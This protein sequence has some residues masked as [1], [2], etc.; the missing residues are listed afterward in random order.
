MFYALF[1]QFLYNFYTLFIQFLY[2]VYT[3]YTICETSAMTKD[4]RESLLASEIPSFFSINES[5]VAGGVAPAPLV[6]SSLPPNIMAPS[7]PMDKKWYEKRKQIK[8]RQITKCLPY[9]II[10]P[11]SYEQKKYKIHKSKSPT[12]AKTPKLTKRM[13]I[14]EDEDDEEKKGDEHMTWVL[15][16]T[17]EVY[18][19][20]SR[21]RSW[22]FK[23]MEDHV[24]TNHLPAEY[25]RR[26][27]EILQEWDEP[28]KRNKK[29]YV[30]GIRVCL[31][32][33][34]IIFIFSLYNFY[35]FFI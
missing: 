18:T 30:D 16:T 14:D 22:A 7:T 29:S 21:A 4:G 32:F 9:I 1:I 28:E 3:G 33:L 34:Y 13:N 15:D 31:Y 27:D 35:I 10:N 8:S 20:F 12:K 5:I 26:E 25:I 6:S 23:Y 19:T 24:E 17:D 11:T 2:Y